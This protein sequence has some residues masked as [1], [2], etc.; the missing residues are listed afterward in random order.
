MGKYKDKGVGFIKHKGETE[1]VPVK[2]DRDGSVRGYHD[3]HWDGS[4]DAAARPRPVKV[5]AQVLQREEK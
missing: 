2:D 4:Q 3:K 5:K 1:R